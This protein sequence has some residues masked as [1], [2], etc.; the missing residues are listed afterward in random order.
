MPIE[1][2]ESARNANGWLE[3]CADETSHFKTMQT[4]VLIDL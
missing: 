3:K 2:G 4:I 1:I